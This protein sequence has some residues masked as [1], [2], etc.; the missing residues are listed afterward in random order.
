MNEV[1]GYVVKFAD[2]TYYATSKVASTHH[3]DKLRK[4]KI[5][6][7]KNF[8]LVHGWDHIVDKNNENRKVIKVVIKEVEE[9]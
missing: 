2:N 8:A 5:F 6:K 9:E 7:S 4:A 3:T 1:I